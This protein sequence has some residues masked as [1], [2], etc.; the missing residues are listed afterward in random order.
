M[1][2]KPRGE[3]GRFVSPK[4]I[5]RYEI[6]VWDLSN[7]NIVEKLWE[8][9]ERDLDRIEEQY[10]DEPGIDIEVEEKF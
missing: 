3:G 5:E 7:G 6:T 10:R 1:T 4:D 2:N 8:A 9:S